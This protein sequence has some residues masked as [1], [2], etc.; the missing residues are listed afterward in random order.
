MMSRRL[1][2]LTT[3]A[4]IAVGTTDISPPPQLS[5][6][7]MDSEAEADTEA[8]TQQLLNESRASASKPRP[9]SSAIL[10]AS[11]LNAARIHDRHSSPT[12]MAR[13]GGVGKLKRPSL[14]VDEQPRKNLAIRKDTY[15][16]MSSPEKGTF[17]LPEKVNHQP[18]RVVRKQKARHEEEA[19]G[20]EPQLPSSSPGYPT[21]QNTRTGSKRKP[22]AAIDNDE[23]PA[24]S[25]RL[26]AQTVAEIKGA[27]RARPKPRKGKRS[28]ASSK[29][30]HPEVRIPAR[31]KNTRKD[32]KD[33]V[34]TDSSRNVEQD[35]S[36]GPTEV[37]MFEGVVQ[38]RQ[39]RSQRRLANGTT[40]TNQH[41]SVAK[42]TKNAEK[43]A[44][45]S[46]P[47][48]RKI[49]SRRAP[50][51]SEA[52]HDDPGADDLF[53]AEEEDD[54]EQPS[55]PPPSND[56]EAVFRFLDLEDRPG[57][58]QTELGTT[59]KRVVERSCVLALSEDATVSAI[60]KSLHDVQV[61]LQRTAEVSEYDDRVNFKSDA[62]GYIFRALVSYLQAVHSWMTKICGPVEDSLESLRLLC[63]LTH[64][65]LAFKDTIAKWNVSVRQRY[66][67]DRIIKD[68]DSILIVPLRSV[69]S[70]F[71]V[72][73]AQ[74]E[75]VERRRQLSADLKRRRETQADEDRKIM[76]AKVAMQERWKRWQNLH[77]ARMECEDDLHKRPKLTVTKFE[78]MEEK[79]A[80]G[81]RFERVPVFRARSTPPLHWASHMAGERE[82]TDEE[83]TALLEGLQRFA[84]MSIQ[85]LHLIYH[86]QPMLTTDP[87]PRVLETIFKIYCRPGGVLRDFS[88][89]EI[90]RKSAWV[91]SAY[92]KLHREKG[93]D[94]PGWVKQ[95]PVLP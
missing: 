68:V 65:I 67:G 19:N 79:D 12:G 14:V 74:L 7:Y 24:K 57:K 88:V 29:N 50:V 66:K 71:N 80:N 36:I 31:V 33:T 10:G 48:R 70:S 77:I 95:I 35:G 16:I 6:T 75:A 53:V 1:P 84:G 32:S 13:K 92:T 91:R 43:I 81:L 85:S 8:A 11:L 62:Y 78:D 15:D 60:I 45:E 76:E 34:E 73:L 49:S 22:D 59:I 64:E 83:E 90:V 38:G 3:S 94:I 54:I 39:T 55:E 46:L 87:G 5:R 17:R 30:A 47:L 93:W 4:D 89:T 44:N 82:W 40:S 51:I 27:E 42:R 26:Q 28:H 63:P 9:Q 69:D 37:P 18:L 86:P 41:K 2:I 52:V 72:R 21:E 25:P 20:D 58:C 61:I 23:N 56:V